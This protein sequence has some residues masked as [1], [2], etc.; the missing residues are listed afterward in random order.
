MRESVDEF[1]ILLDQ[2]K[3]GSEEA[4]RQ[5]IEQYG[6]AIRRSIRRA[7]NPVLRQS[8]DSLDFV[9]LVWK[10]LFGARDKLDRFHEPK[11]LAAYLF[12]MVR[13][14][15]NN[16]IRRATSTR[17]SNGLRQESLDQLLESKGY[18]VLDNC[19]SP[20]QWA[21]AQERWDDLLAGQPAHYR[22]IIELRLQGNT[23]KQ[24]ADSV[25]LN[26][27]TVRRFLEKLQMATFDD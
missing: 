22:R 25:G 15:V 12:G 1:R 8:F 7:L 21:I 26:Q 13:N 11:E 27:S 3:D 19:P 18:H 9:Q 2:V 4:A 20:S 6:D 24:I 16:E 14:K 23:I 10:S 17:K 5:L